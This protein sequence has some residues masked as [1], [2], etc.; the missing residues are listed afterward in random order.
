MVLARAVEKAKSTQGALVAQ[1]LSRLDPYEGVT[2]SIKFDAQ[3]DPVKSAVIMEIRN[4]KAVY[5][6]TFAPK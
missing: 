1:A 3:G 2:G 5:L 6:K 4:G